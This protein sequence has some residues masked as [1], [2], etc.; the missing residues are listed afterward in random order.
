MFGHRV[1]RML[2]WELTRVFLMTLIGL[3]GLFLVGLVVQQANQLGLSLM[4][5]IQAIPLLVPSTLPFT[6]PATTLFAASVAYAR[7]SHDN[8]AVALKAAGVDLYTVLRPAFMLGLITS[9]TTFTLCH[10]IIPQSQ[11]ALQQQVMSDPEEVLYNLLKRDRNF[12]YPNAPYSIYVREVQGRRLIDVVLKKRK[13]LAPG[14]K[15]IHA[16]GYDFI[17]R[18]REAQL[19]VDIDKGILYVKLFGWAAVEDGSKSN[20]STEDSPEVEIPLPE[21]FSPKQSKTRLSAHTWDELPSRALDYQKKADDF[22]SEWEIK[23][24]NYRN[25][26]NLK[27]EKIEQLL[28]EDQIKEALRQRRVV[29]VEYQYRPAL[30]VGCFCFAL[31]GCPV[32]LRASRADYLSVFMVCFLPAVFAYYPLLLAGTNLAKDGKL[33]MVVGVWGAN[34]L[35]LIAFFVLTKLLIRR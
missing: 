7:L 8:E 22:R 23:K 20:I 18:A 31:I 35:A 17:A 25:T 5:T 19:R 11:V 15:D 27:D 33:P 26:N 9:I 12:R 10:T 28:Y 13:K 4:Q 29:E 30:A 6:I 21:M 14:Q 34:G 3:T 2:F 32:G 1:N 16:A 24:A